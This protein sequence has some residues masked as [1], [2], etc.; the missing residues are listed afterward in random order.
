MW[1]TG[2]H[3]R[4]RR[5]TQNFNWLGAFNFSGLWKSSSIPLLRVQDIF[6]GHMKLK[7][8]FNT[9]T[10]YRIFF[11]ERVPPSSTPVTT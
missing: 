7:P 5:S 9:P 8:S 2:V 11:T 10:F 1:R 4:A 6:F 3:A